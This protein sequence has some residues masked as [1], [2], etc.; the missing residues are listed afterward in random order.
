VTQ[1]FTT[2]FVVPRFT[3]DSRRR[4]NL[5][6]ANAA[7]G[8]SCAALSPFRC[9]CYLHCPWSRRCLRRPR[10]MRTSVPAAA[11]TVSTTARWRR[12]RRV[13]QTAQ[14]QLM[15]RA[16]TRD[17]PAIPLLRR[18][19]IF[20]L[21]QTRQRHQSTRA[22]LASP[23]ATRKPNLSSASLPAAPTRSA[24][25]HRCSSPA[26]EHRKW[27]VRPRQ[28]SAPHPNARRNQC[29]FSSITLQSLSSS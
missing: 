2:Y 9:C 22:S 25:L 8:R 18:R 24:A 10:Q 11:A 5:S 16:S 7:S 20:P 12:P 14:P 13:P 4:P 17:A 21:S 28:E 29:S 19:S 23:P 26:P 15:P 1:D 6:Q 27:I 3:S